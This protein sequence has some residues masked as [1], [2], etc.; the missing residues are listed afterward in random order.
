[1]TQPFIGEIRIFAF[2]FPPRRWALCAGQTLAIAQNNALF[3]LLGTTYGGNGV[4][5]FQLPNLQG[6]QPMHVGN[7]PG[8]TPRVLGE[9]GGT[10]SVTL[11]SNQMPVHTHALNAS[12]TSDGSV[13]L[14]KVNGSSTDNL[15]ADPVAVNKKAEASG[16]MAASFLQS[17]GGS[18][19]HENE[20]PTLVMNIS[21]ALQGIVPSRN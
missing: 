4:T 18:Q 21:I 3:A 13:P 9:T 12:T 14:S 16:P 2:N 8:L 6:R 1:M 17:A 15:Y 19:P 5:T 11:S 20:Q 10:A 7:G